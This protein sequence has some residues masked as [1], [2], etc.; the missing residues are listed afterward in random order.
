MKRH[1]LLTALFVFASVTIGAA[2][3]PPAPSAPTPPSPT[4]KPAPRAEAPDWVTQAEQSTPLKLQFVISKYQGDK[5][6]SSVPY[7]VSVNANQRRNTSLRMGGQVPI[8]MGGDKGCELS[9]HR[10]R[11]SMS[12]RN[13]RPASCSGLRLR[14]KTAPYT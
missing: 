8:P 7:V 4:A 3:T 6:I 2:Q 12:R 1:L 13:R 9:R 10:H 11:T 5:K 14:S